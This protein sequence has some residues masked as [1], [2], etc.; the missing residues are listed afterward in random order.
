MAARDV[1]AIA[2]RIAPR[3]TEIR[4]DLHMHPEIA[5][6]EER[7]SS[8]VAAILD[9]L[10]IEVRTGVGRTGVVGILHGA[11]RGKVVALRADMDALPLEEANRV[12][13]RSRNAG[14]MHACGHDGHVAMALGAA[15]ILR[16]RRERLRGAVVFIFQP[17]E[18]IV[19]G[20]RAMIRAGVLEWA[21]PDAII[22]AHLKPDAPFGSVGLRNGLMMAAADHFR[23]TVK[24]KGGHGARPHQANDPILAANEIYAAC[25][26][27]RRNIDPVRRFVLSICAFNAGTAGNVIPD[28]AVMLGTLRTFDADVRRKIK[29]RLAAILK[30]TGSTF[31]VE[32][33]IRY[34]YGTPVVVNDTRMVDVVRAAASDLGAESVDAELTMTGEDFACFQ[35]RI[36]GVFFRFGTQHGRS[37][38][39]LHSTRFDF[40]ERILPIGA[41]LL[42][43]SALRFLGA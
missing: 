15:M 24:G 27:I 23:I 31:G 40:D 37:V 42:A 7:T 34:E 12:A 35:E 18:E 17:A 41:A 8:A 32:C 22:G 20:A 26:T 39:S 6:K 10:D 3:L 9:E 29:R 14:V 2:K 36:P 16:E 13:Y 21:K 25:R 43:Q 4:R 28:T 33:G 5:F 11:R 38:R 19:S 1:H 30:G